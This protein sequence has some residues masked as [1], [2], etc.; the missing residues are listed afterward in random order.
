MVIGELYLRGDQWKFRATG[1]GWS[2]G[3]AGLATDYGITVDDESEVA[4][5]GEAVSDRGSSDADLVDVEPDLGDA[6]ISLVD[7]VD[8][9]NMAEDIVVVDAEQLPGPSAAPDEAVAPAGIVRSARRW[10]K[11]EGL[12]CGPPC[13]CGRRWAELFGP[14]WR[15]RERSAAGGRVAVRVAAVERQSNASR[16]ATG[17]CQCS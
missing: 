7:C 4:S 13:S 8:D 12:T 1:Q 6:P 11:A 5:A 17:R 9:G 3:L 15:N 16:S 2:S 10:R 14:T